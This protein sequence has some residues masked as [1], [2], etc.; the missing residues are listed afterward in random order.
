MS[1]SE[2]A[3]ILFELEPDPE[4]EALSKD[5]FTFFASDSALE[6]FRSYELVSTQPTPDNGRGSQAI[7]L[8][9]ATG[10]ILTVR[11][12]DQVDDRRGSGYRLLIENRK[13][14]ARPGPR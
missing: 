3:R 4:S 7:L 1:D 11:V 6:S 2:A 10:R 14:Y 8:Q 12:G 5:L 13:Y 9:S